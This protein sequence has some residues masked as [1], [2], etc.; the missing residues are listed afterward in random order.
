VSP[1]A[2]RVVAPLAALSVVAAATASCTEEPVALPLRSLAASGAIAFVC[3]DAPD[4]D[5][6]ASFARPLADCTGARTGSTSDYSVP[7]LYA[8]VLQTLRGEVA[9]VDLTTDSRAVLDQNPLVP[10]ATFLPVGAAPADIVA[11]PGGM[12]S[13]VTAAEPGYEGIYGLPSHLIR[14]SS[15]RLST[16]PSCSLPATPGEMLLVVDPPDDEGRLRPAC[17]ADYG[18]PDDTACGPDATP[19][20]HGDLAA[21]AVTSGGGRYKLVVAL[22][23]E[24]GIAV[25]D[26]QNVLDREPGSFEPCT[27]ERWVPLQVSPDTPPAPPLPPEEGCVHEARDDGAGVFADTFVAEPVAMAWSDDRLYVTDGSAPVI[28]VLDMQSACEPIERAPLLPYSAEDPSRIVTTSRLTVSP[29]TL[30]FKRYLYAVDVVDGSVMVFDVSDDSTTRLPLERSRPELNPFQPVDRIRLQTPPRDIVAIQ[31]LNDDHDPQSGA[32]IPV[33]CDPDPDATGP[34]SSYRTASNFESGASPYKLRGVFTFIV[35]AS[36]DVVVVDVDDYDA[37]CRGPKEPHPLFGCDADAE[38]PLATSGEFSCRTVV[39]H[40]TRAGGF[41]VEIDDVA[42]RQPGLVDLPQLFGPNGAALK[43]DN[44]TEEGRAGP[45]MRATVP[46]DGVTQLTLPEGSDLQVLDPATGKLSVT[47]RDETDPTENVLAMNLEEPRAHTQ[48][49]K[50]TVTYEGAIPG[51]SG[52]FAALVNPEGTL[53]LELRDASSYFC[54]RGVLGR[55]AIEEIRLAEGAAPALAAAD[56]DR[57]ADYVHLISSTPVESDDTYWND[58]ETQCTYTECRT[59][60]GTIDEPLGARELRIVEA[61]NHRLELERRTGGI[62][63][64]WLDLLKCCFPSEIEFQVRVSE[65]WAVVAGGSVFLHHVVPDPTTG[66]CRNSCDPQLAL[67]N[68]R[69]REFPCPEHV[70]DTKADVSAEQCRQIVCGSEPQEPDPAVPDYDERYQEYLAALAEYER[71][72]EQLDDLGLADGL[73]VTD[74]EPLAFRNAMFRFALFP[75]EAD[76]VRDM[77]FEFTTKHAFSPLSRSLVVDD[78]DI[79]PQAIEYLTPTGELVISD[80]SLQGI[81]ML[82]LNYLAITRQYN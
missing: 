58:A 14:G 11:T 5:D 1:L 30:D 81:T 31:H 65:Q 50:F 6:P 56:A 44:E 10:G 19:H 13:F 52:R 45:R 79:Q 72:I 70:G 55:T 67:L 22:P 7:H 43:I 74:D 24:G 51:F 15:P 69:A 26:A 20:C 59:A 62:D 63:R 75:G 39:P 34:G 2:Q 40:Q 9:V 27:I 17:D 53:D 16:W 64:E 3:L 82:D 42:N 46:V 77:R 68:S 71:C 54:D 66:A 23:Q 4:G 41:L 29:A 32:N 12:A 60:F 76:S 48:D 80:G 35:L 47:E 37:P 36:G 28:H 78:D 49:W 61:Y 73:K 38:G 18:T 25:I 33:R 21:E 8:L 57:F